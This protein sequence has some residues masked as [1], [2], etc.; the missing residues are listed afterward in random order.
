MGSGSVYE[1][2][3][4][5]NIINDFAKK[6]EDEIKKLKGI[7]KLYCF[8]PDYMKNY[9]KKVISKHFKNPK[10]FLGNYTN[11]HPFEFLEKIQNK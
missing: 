5:N 2:D 4:Q 6:I 7:K 9:L 8:C 3:L 11:K 10:L 1:D